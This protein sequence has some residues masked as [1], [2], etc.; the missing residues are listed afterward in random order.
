MTDQEQQAHGSTPQLVLVR[1]HPFF[2]S[3]GEGRL[4]YLFVGNLVGIASDS[5][6]NERSKVE[7]PSLGIHVSVPWASTVP[8]PTLGA[9]G[10]LPRDWTL[11]FLHERPLHL[12]EQGIGIQVVR[13]PEELSDWAQDWDGR[14]VVPHGQEA[15]VIP[16][17]QSRALGSDPDL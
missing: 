9:G 2:G 5:R 14:A 1:V 13:L 8:P 16:I 4:W 12:E 6:R 10:R 7:I 11:Q 15:P 17:A 3:R